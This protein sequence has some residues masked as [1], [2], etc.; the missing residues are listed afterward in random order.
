MVVGG[1][2]S[3]S[4]IVGIC[5]HGCSGVGRASLSSSSSVFKHRQFLIFYHSSSKLFTITMLLKALHPFNE[6]YLL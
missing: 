3:F 6:N 1:V 2:S 4:S 5:R